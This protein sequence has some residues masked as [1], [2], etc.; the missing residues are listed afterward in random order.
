MGE[1]SL[2]FDLAYFIAIMGNLML[3]RHSGHDYGAPNLDILGKAYIIVCILWTFIISVGVTYFVLHRRLDFVRMRNTTVTICAVLMLH[4]Y[5]C[6]VLLL[7]PI[8][9]RWPC[10]LEY[11]IMS[12]YFPLGVALF[13]AQ[14]SSSHWPTLP[15][16]AGIDH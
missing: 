13:Q 7:Y 6:M 14:V 10:D 3:P 8:N 15:S 11:W 4:I 1:G 2:S 9:G 16:P 12:I 5:L